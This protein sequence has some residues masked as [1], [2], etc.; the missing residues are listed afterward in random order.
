ML[1]RCLNWPRAQR[2]ATLPAMTSPAVLDVSAFID[3]QP[4]SRLQFRVILL[5]GLVVLFDGLDTQVIGYLGPALSL[6]WNIPRAQLGPVFSASLVGLMAGLLIIG[7]ISDRIGRR[8][9][10]I[11]SVFLFSFCTLLTAFAQGVNDQ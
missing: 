2:F 3:L 10:I 5:C 1:I 8:Y 6:E 9:S 11:V 7:P 4:V